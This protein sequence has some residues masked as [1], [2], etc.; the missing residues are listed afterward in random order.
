MIRG[1]T[2]VVTGAASGIGRGIAKALA[3]RGCNLALADLNETGLGE[4]A[5]MLSPHGVTVSCHRLDVADRA[6]I[7]AFPDAVE[8]SHGAADILVNNAGVAVGGTFEEIAE[9]DFEWLFEINFWGVVRMTR[10]FLPLLRCSDDA[11]I[12]NISSLFGLIAPPGQS[13]YCAS[14]FAVRGFSESLRREL[15]AE[16]TKI[17]VTTVHPGGVATS[18]A[19]SA[20][21][22][23]GRNAEDLAR[24]R[25]A[26]RKFLTMPPERAGEIIVAGM[27]R[28][29]PRV[30]VGR[31]AKT[32][33]LIERIAP[34][35]YWK[36]LQRRMR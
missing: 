8:K 11:H 3:C 6:A 7:A 20:R 13:A 14:K 19:D 2:A 26:F 31:D 1:R 4:T 27:E 16:G 35:S 30:I 32:A 10:A 25:D 22:P 17:A 36:Q 28:H 34:V 15:E 24:E 23:R 33:S 21:V 5:A 29:K 9:E 18:I 12:V